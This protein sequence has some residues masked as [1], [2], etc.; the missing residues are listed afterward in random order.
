MAVNVKGNSRRLLST[1]ATALVKQGTFKAEDDKEW[2]MM[3]KGG[4]SL[5]PYYEFA[6]RIPAAAKAKV[7][8]L[9]KRILSGELIVKTNDTQPKST[10]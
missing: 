10:F 8:A 9:T 1:T 6:D 3:R 4:A 7:D 5:S 2:T